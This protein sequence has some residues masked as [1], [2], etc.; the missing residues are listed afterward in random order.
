MLIAHLI[1]AAIAVGA[2]LATRPG[3]RAPTLIAAAA[4]LVDLGLGAPLRPA[5]MVTGPLLLFLTAALTLAALVERSGFAE[6][7]AGAL[8]SAASGSALLLYMLVCLLCGLLTAAVS[9]DGAVVLMVPLLLALARR[10][11]A[12]F[13]PLFLGA[14]VVANAASIAVPQGNPTNLVIIGRLGLSPTAFVVHMLAPGVAAAAACAGAVALLERRALAG[15]LALARSD[16]TP[17]SGAERHAALSLSLAAVAAWAAP[18]VGIAPWWPFAGAVALALLTRRQRPRLVVPWSIAIQVSALV[19]VT[20]AL[21]VTL[22]LPAA[23]GLGVL[24]G[25]AALIG[26][27]CATL[28]NLPVSVWAAGLLSATRPAYAASIGLAVGSLATPQGSVATL[29]AA[30][31]AGSSAPRLSARRLA[32]I[33]AAGLLVATAALWATL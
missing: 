20:S 28:N 1:L 23:A 16:G 18:L 26:L 2:L 8:A 4:A 19:V 30:Q 17:L 24:L 7:L 29:I 5:V 3:R 21:H 22:A 11:S 10:F 15:R 32:P 27:A 6:R 31:L 25:V 9:L 14:V 13:A 33:A 12:P